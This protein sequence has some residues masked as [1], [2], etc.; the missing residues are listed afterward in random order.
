[1][2]DGRFRRASP[3]R[4][5]RC[6]AAYSRMRVLA[7]S[8][9]TSVVLIATLVDPLLQ[10]SDSILGRSP[11]P[12]SQLNDCARIRTQTGAAYVTASEL[13][14]AYFVGAATANQCI[15]MLRLA[16]HAGWLMRQPARHAAR[17]QPC[18]C[19]WMNQLS[20]CES[21]ACVNDDRRTQAF[22]R[23]PN[24]PFQRSVVPVCIF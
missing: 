17:P 10:C 24:F 3:D 13:N 21:I 8:P 4:D 20:S 5:N 16:S 7:Y 12:L 6:L 14:L 18:P 1:M 19:S 9:A 23:E 11:A 22:T 15:R 2:R